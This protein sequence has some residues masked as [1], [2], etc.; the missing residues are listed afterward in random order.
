MRHGLG[1]R[2]DAGL[3]LALLTES[4]Q[5]RSAVLSQTLEIVPTLST[6]PS[7]LRALEAEIAK[8]LSELEAML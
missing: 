2:E 4:Q 5:I 3:R 8:D 7:G 6:A 1:F